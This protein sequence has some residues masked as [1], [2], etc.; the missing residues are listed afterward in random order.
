MTGRKRNQKT[1]VTRANAAKDTEAMRQV[2][3]QLESAYDH[4]R[5][6]DLPTQDKQDLS[7]SSKGEAN[8]TPRVRRKLRRLRGNIEKGSRRSR[9][10]ERGSRDLFRVFR[11]VCPNAAPK[12]LEWAIPRLLDTVYFAD[13][14]SEKL[15]QIAR[16]KGRSKRGE[17]RSIV[18]EIHELSLPGLRRQLTG[19]RR[20]IPLILKALEPDQ[21]PIRS[22]K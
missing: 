18:M 16:V 7:K 10:L 9:A 15:R 1:L 2:M 6:L 21:P 8:L 5:L 17:V 22:P 19:L 13:I 3:A 20:D 14:L 12:L 11:S 4:I